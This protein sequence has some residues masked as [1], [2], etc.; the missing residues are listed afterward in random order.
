ML[1]YQHTFHGLSRLRWEVKPLIQVGK[2][3]EQYYCTIWKPLINFFIYTDY[4]G[5]PYIFMGSRKH[6]RVE[7][8]N[9]LSFTIQVNW[10]LFIL[11]P[12]FISL[13]NSCKGNSE[14]LSDINFATFSIHTPTNLG[15]DRLAIRIIF[16]LLS[17]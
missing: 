6:Q 4:W 2:F 10:S 13:Q 3:T 8:S 9:F 11:Y 17:S 14:P 15:Y 1:L 16:G 5:L 12:P 7:V